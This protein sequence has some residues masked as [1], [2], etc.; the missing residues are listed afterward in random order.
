MFSVLETN[1][2]TVSHT[3]FRKHLQVNFLIVVETRNA[4][5]GVN[6]MSDPYSLRIS[7]NVLTRLLRALSWVESKDKI[8]SISL[9]AWKQSPITYPVRPYVLVNFSRAVSNDYPR[10][11]YAINRDA[12]GT[13]FCQMGLSLFW[14]TKQAIHS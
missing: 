13:K 2:W 6:V 12:E 3:I 11:I 14:W 4:S 10:I 1:M 5:S 9:I 7:V 8:S